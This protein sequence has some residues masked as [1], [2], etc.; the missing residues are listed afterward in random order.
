MRL[1]IPKLTYLIALPLMACMAEEEIDTSLEPEE[2]H[3]F[4]GIWLYINEVP[5]E[6]D[7]K[8]Y[9]LINIDNSGL[10]QEYFCV[11]SGGFIP[12][13]L[14]KRLIVDGKTSYRRITPLDDA[15]SSSN[16]I[17]S[18]E[19]DQLRLNGERVSD[20]N[21][22]AEPEK[23]EYSIAYNK[24]DAIPANC[25][26]NAIQLFNIL[27]TPITAGSNN[28]NMTFDYEYKIIHTGQPDEDVRL[29]FNIMTKD[30]QGEVINFN[31]EN[32]IFNDQP[33]LDGSTVSGSY[34]FSLNFAQ[35]IAGEYLHIAPAVTYENQSGN[36]FSSNSFGT[37]EFYRIG[38]THP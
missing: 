28:I 15:P 20:T 23:F 7:P 14:N 17:Y 6:S 32:I 24:L 9:F 33:I 36:S 34:T 1:P 5:E 12:S 27:P 18:L 19:G 21:T 10:L 25:N 13:D 4:T 22:T 8:I 31:P 35:A 37:D 2:A 29:S 38:I 3:P 26:D 30:A 16:E 11:P